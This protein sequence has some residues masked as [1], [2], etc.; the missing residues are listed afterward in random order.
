MVREDWEKYRTPI[1]SLEIGFRCELVD[2]VSGDYALQK[3]KVSMQGELIRA[4]LIG[5]SAMSIDN[6]VSNAIEAGKT[7][8]VNGACERMSPADRGHFRA[9]VAALIR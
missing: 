8:A 3:L 1:E 7:Q 5:D 9:W 6:F 2:K 4:G